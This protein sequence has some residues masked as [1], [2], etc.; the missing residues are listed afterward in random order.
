MGRPVGLYCLIP[1]EPG[2]ELHPHKLPAY[3]PIKPGGVG[4]RRSGAYPSVRAVG[5]EGGS[6]QIRVVLVQ[7]FWARAKPSK[8][9]IPSESYFKVMLRHSDAAHGPQGRL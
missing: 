2:P 3:S 7:D 1:E 8:S 5:G 6:T 9:N 4:G